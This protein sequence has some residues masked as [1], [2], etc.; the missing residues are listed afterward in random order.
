MLTVL[1]V[2]SDADTRHIY[3]EF[4]RYKG[5]RTVNATTLA[6][7]YALLESE[8]FHIVVSELHLPDGPG[9]HLIHAV[10]NN[11]ALAQ[12]PIIAHSTDSHPSSA[13]RALLAGADA[14]VAK[15]A[16]A[17]MLVAKIESLAYGRLDAGGSKM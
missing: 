5:H 12:I 14:F 7:A 9:L 10:R 8:P 17:L 11:E 4:L 15:P 3:A 13:K 2:E 1:L 6:E 16:E